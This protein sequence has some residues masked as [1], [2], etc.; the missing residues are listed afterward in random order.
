MFFEHFL[1]TRGCVI[2]TVIPKGLCLRILRDMEKFL[3]PHIKETRFNENMHVRMHMN[4][5]YCVIC[6][7]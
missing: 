2:L 1:C 5:M 3:F 6:K 7:F 4:N